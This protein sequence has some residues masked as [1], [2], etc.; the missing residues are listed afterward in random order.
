MSI[1]FATVKRWEIPEGVVKQVECNGIVLWELLNTAIVTI[2]SKWAGMDGDTA[3]ITINS[4][5][6]FKPTPSSPPTPSWATAVNC[7]PNYIMEV[8]I[9]ST[10]T[11]TVSR[12]KG[13]AE[14]FIKLNG[15][16]VVT[17]EGSY[18]YTVKGNVTIHIEDKYSQ[19]DYGMITI[20]EV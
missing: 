6:L 14:S 11:C 16:N 2:T 7:E 12:D 15:T 19:G 9:G 4:P 1:D 20:T 3:S 8:P 17:G 10:I 13:N 18:I 5:T